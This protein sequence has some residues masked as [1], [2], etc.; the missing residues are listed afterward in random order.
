R[1]DGRPSYAD[2][3]PIVIVRPPSVYGPREADIY[4]MFQA[5]QRGVFPVLGSG[6][7]PDVSL[8]HVRDLVAGMVQAAEA[9]NA[10]GRTYF[11]GSADFYSWREVHR[12][13]CSALGRYSFALPVWPPLTGVVGAA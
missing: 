11:L 1:R 4:T 12:A 3:L 7:K 2:Q 5:A 6:R 9:P 8:V 10:T 13:M